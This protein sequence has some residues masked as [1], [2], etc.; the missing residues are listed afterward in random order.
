MLR[1][2]KK[3]LLVVILSLLIINLAMILFGGKIS[4]N[5]GPKEFIE[6]DFSVYHSFMLFSSEGKCRLRYHSEDDIFE[7]ASLLHSAFDRP[8]MFFPDKAQK[9]LFCLYDF[10]VRVEL[11]IFEIN[12]PCADIPIEIN[13]IV[14]NS[15]W[16]VK[17]GS[18]DEIEYF[19]KHV[20][21]FNSELIKQYSIP[22]IDI[23][24]FKYYLTKNQLQAVISR[25]P[26]PKPKTGKER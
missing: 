18:S 19:K 9:R 3:M 14:L 16:R 15:A 21:D 26:Y 25:L 8:I 24:P 7:F 2:L 1:K 17:Q 13:K 11:L 10:D 5:I 4:F 12:T 22:T 6:A 20:V 23:G